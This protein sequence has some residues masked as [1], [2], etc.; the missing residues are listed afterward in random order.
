MQAHYDM[1]KRTLTYLLPV[2][3]FAAVSLQ[4]QQRSML[5][6]SPISDGRLVITMDK[7]VYFPDD[8]LRM[9]I[10]QDAGGRA[11]SVTPIIPL[12]GMTLTASGRDSFAAIVP[13]TVIPGMYRILLRVSDEDGR[14]ML[15]ETDRVVEIEEYRAVEQLCDYVRVG[16]VEGGT[17][18]NDAVTLNS[19][20]MR[21][22]RI[23]FLRDSIRPRMG[24]QFVT[25]TTIV[26]PR[27]GP[28]SRSFERR[29]VTFRSHGDP[30]KDRAVFTQYRTVYGAYAAI[31]P[32]ELESVRVPQDSLPA[33]ALI[34]VTIE[35][36]NTIRMG[37][38]DRSNS[39]VRYYR[40]KGPAIEVGFSLGIPKVL[41]DT[42]SADSVEYGSTSAMFRLY[43]VDAESGNRFPVSLGMGT[44][45]VG[46]PIDVGAGRGGFAL[47]AVLD[48]VELTR[49]RELGMIKKFYAGLELTL[50]SPIER[51]IRLLL[52]A[53]VGFS[54]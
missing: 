38:G 26:Q 15:Y 1:L 2:C 35:P 34:T 14:R 31:S 46:S 50:F 32:E 43:R 21:D 44:F 6:L 30:A 40:V 36:D 51:R 16:P 5:L 10:R 3:L 27:D 28:A 17:A 49:I 54:L 20:E 25:I 13:T 22:L 23:L 52:N 8:T 33:W 7:P 9:S 12:E 29:V 11:L 48:V 18:P 19:S 4:A 37:G 53:Q 47:S 41:Y 45:G 42:Q 39:V 24:P